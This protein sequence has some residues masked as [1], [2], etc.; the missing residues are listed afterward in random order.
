MANAVIK[1]AQTL[2][3]SAN[4]TTWVDMASLAATEFEA[5]KTYLIIANQICNHG[6]GAN[7]SRV[8]LVHGTTPTVFDDAS[9]AWEGVANTM[10]HEESY[11]FLYTQPATAE[12][13][14]LQISSSLTTTVTNSLSQI[15]AIKLS[16]DFV[17]GTDYFWNEFLTDYTMTATPVAKAITASFTPNGT[18]RWLFVGHM[19]YDV[20]T[21]VD[22]IGFELFDSVAGVLGLSWIE[23]E[24]TVNDFHGHNVYWVGVPT[25]AARTLAVRP[26]EE[27]GSNIMLASRV[28]AFN[29]SKFAQSVSVFSAAEVDPATTPTY[30]T[31]ATVAPTPNVTGDW[32]Y[33]A[34]LTQ[35]IN[36]NTTL[37][38]FETRLQV[39]PDGAGLV[40]DPQYST[41]V[42]GHDFQ[43][44]L[45]ETGHSIFKLRSLTSGAARTIN[46]DARRVNGTLG[47]LKDNGLVAFSVALASVAAATPPRPTV[48]TDAVRR[49]SFW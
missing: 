49:A 38:D 19:I 29:L 5:N 7:E 16:D 15:I 1:Y 18:D 36:E 39:N 32:V 4:S 3:G 47:R 34:F 8:R 2:V 21:I 20:V 46:F 48:A 31:V 33:L 10:K 11:L 37:L 23:G 45:D 25:N 28:L 40:S 14:K 12:L 26:V 6:S 43:D 24:D 41:T 9:L 30:T 44:P 13:I 17:S 22:Q 42:P 35:D 27:A